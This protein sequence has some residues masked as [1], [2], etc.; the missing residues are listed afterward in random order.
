MKDEGREQPGAAAERPAPGGPATAP[1]RR[2]ATVS[3]PPRPVE[4]H[5]FA[6]ASLHA[7]LAAV[8]PQPLRVLP[9]PSSEG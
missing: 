1:P 6:A 7:R 8:R 3:I 2:G 4:A 5:R 9:V